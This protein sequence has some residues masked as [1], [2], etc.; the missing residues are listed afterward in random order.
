MVRFYFERR[1]YTVSLREFVIDHAVA[2]GV[3]SSV[4][5]VGP[6]TD[7]LQVA[8]VATCTLNSAIVSYRIVASTRLNFLSQGF[9]WVFLVQ[10]SGEWRFSENHTGNTDDVRC[11]VVIQNKVKSRRG[12]HLYKYV[13]EDIC[14]YFI[15]T[16]VELS[17]TLQ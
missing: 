2:T 8:M 16:S 12:S 11:V 15:W 14:C 6:C 10:K 7:L 4:L 5:R 17:F 3:C 9:F 13:F 1:P